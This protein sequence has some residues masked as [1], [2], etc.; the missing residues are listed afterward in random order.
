MRKLRLALF[1]PIIQFPIAYAL[2][3]WR[4]QFNTYIGN[5]RAF[6]FAINAPIM[7]FL[8]P[9]Y[10]MAP[11]R[12]MPG[13]ILG[14][15]SDNLLVLAGIVILWFLVGLALDFGWFDRQHVPRKQALS[16]FRMLINLFVVGSGVWLFFRVGMDWLLRTDSSQRHSPFD[17]AYGI[18]AI[19]WALLL[20]TAAGRR[21]FDI[22]RYRATSPAST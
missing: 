17:I 10:Q 13:D 7:L 11:I 18:I 22:I 2:L 3:T 9:F 15:R 21:L 1:L 12:W 14:V 19:V 4:G 6:C 5:T 20:T 16:K 8:A